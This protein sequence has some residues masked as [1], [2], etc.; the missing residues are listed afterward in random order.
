MDKEKILAERKL[1]I[2]D[3]ESNSE[4]EV[5]LLLG[6]PYWRTRGEEACCEVAI[7]SVFDSFEETETKAISGVDFFQAIQ[8]GLGFFDVLLAHLPEKY[9]ICWP[10]GDRYQPKG[11][12]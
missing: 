7:H 8:L 10:D 3:S 9:E 11:R 2:K 12:P 6:Y 4:G 5:V 1:I